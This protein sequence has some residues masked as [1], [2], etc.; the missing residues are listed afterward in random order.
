MGSGPVAARDYYYYY[1]YIYLVVFREAKYTL[2]VFGGQGMAPLPP[3]SALD[4][5]P[6]RKSR[7]FR[8]TC[9]SLHFELFGMII[10]KYV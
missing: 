10:R 3:G 6:N 5:P 8:A 9:V 4:L 1:F 2:R 7:Q